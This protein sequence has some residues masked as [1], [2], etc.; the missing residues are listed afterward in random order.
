MSRVDEGMIFL[1]LHLSSLGM[2]AVMGMN[3]VRQVIVPCL[4]RL[5]YVGGQ[6]HEKTKRF[7]ILL[8]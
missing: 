2:N 4:L 3:H 8:C 5:Y 7:W 6:T 1:G